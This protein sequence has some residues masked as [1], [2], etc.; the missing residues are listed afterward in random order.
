VNRRKFLQ[1]A[2][3]AAGL[4]ASATAAEVGLLSELMSWLKRRPVW[5]IPKTAGVLTASDLCNAVNTLTSQTYT[6]GKDGYFGIVNPFTIRDIAADDLLPELSAKVL[7]Y[8]DYA[9]LSSLS[10]AT[11][12]GQRK[13]ERSDESRL[14]YT[15]DASGKICTVNVTPTGG[16]VFTPS[17]SLAFRNHNQKAGA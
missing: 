4:T 12:L 11:R 8:S 17:T 7:Q 15:T 9:S 2:G 6:V 10:L 5:S 3:C 14:S 16:I 13:I 1:L